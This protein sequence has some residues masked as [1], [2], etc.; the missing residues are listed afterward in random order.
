MK[1][2]SSL[3]NIF[4]GLKKFYSL[5]DAFYSPCD[6]LIAS[7]KIFYSRW[8]AFYSLLKRLPV[9][10]KIFFSLNDGYSSLW[11]ALLAWVKIYLLVCNEGS[12]KKIAAGTY[13]LVLKSV[14]TT[15][16]KIP[17]VHKINAPEIRGI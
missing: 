9:S 2:N 4:C 1:I 17:F 12:A 6:G 16:K 13:G 8:D 15:K 7:L 14:L 10:L 5:P 3:K 11:D